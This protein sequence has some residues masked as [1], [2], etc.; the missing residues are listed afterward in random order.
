MSDAELLKRLE[1]CFEKDE[2]ET[3][4]Y[5]EPG[6]GLLVSPRTAAIKVVHRPSGV[7]GMSDQY[8][9]QVRNKVAALLDVLRK[10]HEAAS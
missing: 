5:W 6:S 4:V 2:I 8:P 1:R 7:E 9:S 10:L 3:L